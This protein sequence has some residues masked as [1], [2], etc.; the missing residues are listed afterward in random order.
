MLCGLVH[1]VLTSTFVGCLQFGQIPHPPERRYKGRV[2]MVHRG[3]WGM[4][5][6]LRSSVLA[7]V[8]GL[9]ESHP[10][11]ERVSVITCGHSMGGAL[12]RL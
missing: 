9:F 6:A 8:R 10:T 12:Y 4:W 3:F 1:C 2:P 11:P 7:H 5:A